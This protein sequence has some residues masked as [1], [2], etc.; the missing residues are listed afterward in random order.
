MTI[1]IHQA[2]VPVAIRNLNNLSEILKKAEAYA[3]VKKIEP[4]VLINA[5][6]FPDMLPLARQIQIACDTVKAGAARLAEI[7]VPSHPDVEQTFSELR[8]RINT[9]ISFLQTIQ[10]EQ[11]NGKDELKISYVAHGRERNFIGLPYLLSYLLPNLY[12]HI[13]TAYAILRH[14]GLEIGKKDYL[15]RE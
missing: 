13:T 8:D 9:T 5:R 4:S 11:I 3:E 2:L 6:L 10:P 12:F 15:G 14:N 1:S 7:P